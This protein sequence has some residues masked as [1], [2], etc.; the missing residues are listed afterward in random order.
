MIISDALIYQ[1][2]KLGD[3][4]PLFLAAEMGHSECLKIMLERKS[5]N[6]NQM[7]KSENGNTA[8]H[9]AAEYGHSECIKVLLQNGADPNLRN[10]RSV[11]L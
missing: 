2:G 9:V 4:S 3:L 7:R 6:C 5:V 11:C 10:L 1:E 8:L